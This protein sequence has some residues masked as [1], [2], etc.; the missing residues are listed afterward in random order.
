MIGAL[1][2]AIGVG[3]VAMAIS[4][5]NRQTPATPLFYRAYTV[6]LGVGALWMLLSLLLSFAPVTKDMTAK[7]TVVGPGL[8]MVV[9]T[10]VK[11]RDC[12]WLKSDAYVTDVEG[13]LD[14]SGELVSELSA[15]RAAAMI[16]DGTVSGG[17]IPKIVAALRALDGGAAV[18]IIDGRVEHAL[19]LELLTDT[20]VGTML[21]TELDG[22][23]E[24]S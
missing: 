2:G 7:V 1:E 9:Q 4:Q 3:M 10:G 23:E 8:M 24:E 13:V 21:R 12:R 22:A 19:L 15:R 17:M 20:G 6:T 16:R 14:P 11:T 18:H 5:A